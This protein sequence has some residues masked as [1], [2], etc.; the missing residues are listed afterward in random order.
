MAELGC[1]SCTRMAGISA[2][3]GVAALREVDSYLVVSRPVVGAGLPHL[4]GLGANC[5]RE[6]WPP[7]RGCVITITRRLAVS[8]HQVYGKRQS[9]TLC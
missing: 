3:K 1:R 8:R 6:N 4:D 2:G 7:C 5:W 9:N